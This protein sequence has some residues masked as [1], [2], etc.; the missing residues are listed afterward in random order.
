MTLSIPDKLKKRMNRFN[1]IKWS[2][3]SRKVI[4]EKVEDLEV[5]EEIASKSKLTKKDA[6]KLGKELNK[7]LSKKYKDN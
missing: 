2:D 3:V 5:M 1:E 7:N 4:K 6:V